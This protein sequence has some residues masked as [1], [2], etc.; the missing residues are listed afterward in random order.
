MDIKDI[1]K[2]KEKLKGGKNSQL[3]SRIDYNE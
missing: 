1:F 2:T 3:P